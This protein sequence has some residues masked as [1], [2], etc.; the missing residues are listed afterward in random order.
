MMGMGRGRRDV[1]QAGIAMGALTPP[2]DGSRIIALYHG[3]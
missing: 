1:N 3:V 2:F